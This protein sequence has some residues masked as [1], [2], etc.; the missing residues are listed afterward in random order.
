MRGRVVLLDYQGTLCPRVMQ[1]GQA[2]EF[3]KALQ[4][5]GDLVILWTGSS[6]GGIMDETPN[7]AES[8]DRIRSKCSL[9]REFFEEWD[10]NDVEATEVVVLD[11]DRSGGEGMAESFN[12]V[13]PGIAK[14]VPAREWQAL[15]GGVS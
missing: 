5:Q 3:V 11:D 13:K 12:L 6:I 9:G 1:P 14:W 4:A 15:I 10:L 7:L 8:V 2:L